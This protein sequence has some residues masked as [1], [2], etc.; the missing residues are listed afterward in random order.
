MERG[1]KSRVSKARRSRSAQGGI[2][3]PT[4]EDGLQRSE[5]QVALLAKGCQIAAQARECGSTGI[6][7][8]AAGHFLLHLAGPQVAL[9]LVVVERDRQVVEEGEHLLLAQPPTFEE[10]ARRRLLDPSPLPRAALRWRIGGMAGGE[11]G[12][13]TGDQRRAG[14]GREVAKAGSAC[15]LDAR[16]HLQQQRLELLGPGLCYFRPSSPGFLLRSWVPAY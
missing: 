7:A 9:G 11:Q 1:R 14:G 6:A 3:R 13:V 16:L 5:Q 4:G 10:I 15:L 2:E 12:L 8:E